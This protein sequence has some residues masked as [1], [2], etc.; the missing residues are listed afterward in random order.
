[1]IIGLCGLA[2]SGKSVVAKALVR[3]YGY[4]RRPFAYPL[5]CMAGQ[6]GIS[7]EVLD[8]PSAVKE[9]PLEQLGGKS[10]RYLLQTLGTE[11]GRKCMGEDFWVRQW[12]ATKPD[13]DRIVCDDVRFGNE[14]EAIRSLGGL[15]V[16]VQRE[17]AGSKVGA[18]HASETSMGSISVDCI[19]I[20]DGDLADLEAA[21][22]QLVEAA[23]AK[24]AA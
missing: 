8:G 24:A 13:F 2:G 20:N 21:V 17:G 19:I 4:V 10:V 5:K 11:W 22:S 12:L 1:M 14:A 9:L 6:L 15:I 3:N 16:R 18:G 23:H 7:T